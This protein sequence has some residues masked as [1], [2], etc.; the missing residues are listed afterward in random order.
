MLAMQFQL[1]QTQWWSGEELRAQQ[2]RQL[3]LLLRH[4]AGTVPFYRD[5]LAGLDRAG[6]VSPQAFA[7]IPVLQRQDIQ[8]DF[9]AL[10][11]IRMP[12]DHGRCADGQ[13]TGSTGRPIRFRGTD[14]T[15]LFWCALSLRDH[16]WHRRNFSGKLAVIRSK[17]DNVVQQ[18]WGPVTDSIFTTGPCAVLN[19]G[20]DVEVQLD[21]LREQDPDYVLTHPSNLQALARRALELGVKLTRLRDARTF[22]ET[23]PADLRL[24]CRNAWAVPVTDMYSAEETG[25]IALQCP[26]H[27]HYHVQAENLI[28]EILDDAGQPCA[29]GQIG[30]VVITTLHNFAMPLIRYDIGDYAEAGAPCACGRGLPVIRRIMGRVRNM[31]TFPN[32]RRL[33]PSLPSSRWAS[34]APV[35]QYQMVQHTV[36]DIE[37]R[38]VVERPLT[39]VEQERL[40]AVFQELLG[41]PFRFRISRVDAIERGPGLKFEDFVSR[42]GAAGEPR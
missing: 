27:E 16:F 22:G 39:A 28:V 18:G 10:L 3:S 13:T 35:R 30:R 9:E 41:Y 37:A 32:G 33:W 12:R 19:I 26:E 42:V 5:R 1:E 4:A 38:L 17:V 2:F 11:S 21:W 6:G 20:T 36:S 23:L 15:H 34:V 7:A 31:L 40:I 14:V 29:P 25:Y 24:L 8:L